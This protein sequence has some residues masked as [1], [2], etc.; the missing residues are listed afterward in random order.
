[1]NLDSFKE[2]YFKEMATLAPRRTKI[3]NDIV[4]TQQPDPDKSA[5]IDVVI[6]NEK[7]PYILDKLA[8]AKQVNPIPQLKK[9]NKDL[10]DGFIS[11]NIAGLKAI[12]YAGQQGFKGL[13]IGH[14][15]DY[16]EDDVNMSNY[17]FLGYDVSQYLFLK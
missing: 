9:E 7:Y 16:L 14:F 4:V 5:Y 15:I 2:F 17:N 6:D 11:K 12:Y 10:L 1:M 8:F 3:K 13:D